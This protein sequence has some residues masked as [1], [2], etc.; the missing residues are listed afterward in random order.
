MP[1]QKPAHTFIAALVIN[2]KTWKQPRSPSGNEWINCRT[3]ISQRYC[4]F[5]SKP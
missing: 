5:G 1:T 2:A 4:G 3:G